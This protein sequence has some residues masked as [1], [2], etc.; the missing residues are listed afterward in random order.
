MTD[1]STM[2]GQSF[3]TGALHGARFRAE[4]RA[5]SARGA[6]PESA[7]I[8]LDRAR[9]LGTVGRWRWAESP[10][11]ARADAGADSG[12]PGRM[13]ARNLGALGARFGRMFSTSDAFRIE[14]PD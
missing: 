6:A 5:D 3:V 13:L 1:D 11:L 10:A 14:N 2:T 7:R 12:E 9:N 4:S 8:S